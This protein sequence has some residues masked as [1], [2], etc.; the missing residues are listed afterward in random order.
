MRIII[1]M[2]LV[3]MNSFQTLSLMKVNSEQ[4]IQKNID[5][6]NLDYKIFTTQYDE[7]TKAENLENA[8]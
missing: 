4:I 7:V 8:R 5:N 2:N 6:I 1:L 3:L